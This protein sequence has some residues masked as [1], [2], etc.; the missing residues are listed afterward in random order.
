[1]EERAEVIY[2]KTGGCLVGRNSWLAKEWTWPFAGLYIYRDALVLSMSFHR[3]SLPRA[4]ISQIRRCRSGLSLGAKDRA[5]RFR[6]SA[7][8][9]VLPFGHRGV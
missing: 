3:Y 8:H 4:A 1:M 7:I 9:G 6:L 5:Y 2:A